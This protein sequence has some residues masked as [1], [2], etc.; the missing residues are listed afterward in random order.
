MYAIRS[1]YGNFSP[2]LVE[3]LFKIG[4]GE[5]TLI[6]VQEKDN[7][8]QLIIYSTEFTIVITS[9]SIHY[10]KLYDLELRGKNIDEF[11]ISL[12][13]GLP[14]PRTRSTINLAAEFGTRG[15]TSN[16]LIKDNYVKFTLGLSI[17][18]RGFIIRKYD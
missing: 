2:E 10:T 4:H 14:L 12:G 1:Y 9:Y 6:K 17:F 13:V 7:L 11:G 8:L 5:N 18:E 15:T 3:R 16:N